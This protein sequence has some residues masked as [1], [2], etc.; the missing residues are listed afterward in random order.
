MKLMTKLIESKYGSWPPTPASTHQPTAQARN[1]PKKTFLRV[2]GWN[3]CVACWR[4]QRYQPIG[5]EM[6]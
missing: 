1:A 4:P 6:T 3:E 5:W 2:P